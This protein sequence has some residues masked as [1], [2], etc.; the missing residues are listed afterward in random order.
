MFFSVSKYIIVAISPV[1]EMSMSEALKSISGILKEI[2]DKLEEQQL[3]RI[4]QYFG[5]SMT[6]SPY[7][8]RQDLVEDLSDMRNMIDGCKEID[9]GVYKERVDDYIVRLERVR[10]NLVPNFINNI[11]GLPQLVSSFVIT[12]DGLRKVLDSVF[13]MSNPVKVRDVSKKLSAMESRLQGLE[14][15]LEGIDDKV[16]TIESAYDAADQLPENLN[17]LRNARKDV[18][19]IVDGLKIDQDKIR[20]FKK[21]SED[22]FKHLKLIDES[23]SDVLSRCEKAYSAATSVGLALAFEERSKLLS[24][25]MWYW[26]LGL[27]VSLCAGWWLGRS[28]IHSLLGVVNS[29]ES[30]VFVIFV[31]ILFSVMSIGAPIW[32]AWLAT[33]QIGQRFRLAEDYAFKASI[34]R[35]YEGYRREAARIGGS[36]MEEKLL[37]SALTRLD[38]LPLRLVET[39]S[40][41]SPWHELFSSGAVKKALE[42]VPGFP[43]QVMDLAR[44][45][46]HPA[47]S[48]K[49]VSTKRTQPSSKD[50]KPGSV[51]HEDSE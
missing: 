6:G 2:V 18:G 40:Y 15:R 34:S 23:A 49:S 29:Q 32:F 48:P 17:S 1:L 39:P 20:G 22:I 24:K 11:N 8:T 35:A 37:A 10:D 21:D 44:G 41:G 26:V 46:L 47:T 36:D 5:D 16:S 13:E 3:N 12:M 27:V 51:D 31:N 45:A 43:G 7:I 9:L 50:M 19:V 4:G 28:Q 14:P 33:K 42:T 25:S 30:S 38:E